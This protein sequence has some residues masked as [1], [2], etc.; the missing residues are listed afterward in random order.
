MNKVF[1]FLP[2]RL[3]RSRSPS[4]LPRFS[5]SSSPVRSESPTRAQLTNSSRYAR[6]VSRF[7]DL[8]AVERLEAQSLLRRYITDLEMVQRIIFI[9]VMVCNYSIVMLHVMSRVEVCEK[10]KIKNNMFI[11]KWYCD[12]FKKSS[13]WNSTCWNAYL[14]KW[15][16][17]ETNFSHKTVTFDKTF[18]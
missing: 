5:H 4:P 14:I 12:Q 18:K 10:K 16:K 6:L 7:S 13:L 11:N 17:P 1:L 9:A 8:Y 3:V 15:I 2:L